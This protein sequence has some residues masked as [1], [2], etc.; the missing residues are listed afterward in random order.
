MARPP[1]G[2]FE[3]RVLRARTVSPSFARVTFGG[4]DLRG[5]ASGGRDQ[6]FKLFLP[7]PGQERPLVPSG[8]GTDWYAHWREMDPGRRAVM[9]SY[10]VGE[11]RRAPEE[12]DVD[13]VLHGDTGTASRWAAAARPGDRAVLLG[14]TE[15]DNAGVDFRPPPATDWV[16]VA[17]DATA[18]P[19]VAGILRALPDGLPARVIVEVPHAADRRPLPT[20]ADADITWL[21]PAPD[22]PGITAT[23]SAADLP[24]GRPYVWIAGEAGGVRALRRHLVDVRRIDRRRVTFTGYWRRGTTEDELL[25]QTTSGATGE[26]D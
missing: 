23:V 26:E 9:R 18:L 5:L 21:H 11:Q 25:A 10:T 17:G 20:R 13:F 15:E 8:A 16:L 7:H 4:G 14:P 1:F 3:V 19:A 2:F 24:E 12:L 6:R 22:T